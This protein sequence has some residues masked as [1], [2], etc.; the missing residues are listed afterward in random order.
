MATHTPDSTEPTRLETGTEA[1]ERRIFEAH[2]GGKLTVEPT[3]P[4]DNADDLAIV[5]TPG[6]A[7]VVE[8]I[9]EKPEKA[10][11]YTIKKNTVAV[12][13]DGSAILGL[14]D[15]GP[16]AAL[17]VMEGKAALFSRFADVDAFPICLDAHEVEDIVAHVKAIAPAFAGINLEDISAPR[18]FEIE[19]RLRAELDIP[20]FHDDQHGTAVCVLA[21]L[22]NALTIVEKP[23]EEVRIAMSGAGAAGT[24]ILRLLLA[25]G[26]RDVIVTNS[27]GIVRE[28]REAGDRLEWIARH[29][30]PRGVEG[31]L[32]EAVE[33]A[34]VFIG[35]SVPNIL[36]E[37]MLR[38]M[39][40]RA[41]V[42]AL[43]NPVPEV[44]PEIAWKYA[45]VV[46]TG[47]SDFANQINNVLAF[48]GVFRGLIDAH[49]CEVTDEALLAAAQAIASV[50]SEDE[51]SA[52][53]I[54]PSVFDERVTP[55]VARA[56]AR[57]GEP[58]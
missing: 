35:V 56:V 22:T 40:E 38:S 50:V 9:A 52:R 33:G 7:R 6:V 13:T 20:V 30:N 23:I 55:A 26:A 3:A 54:V 49:A 11:E 21:A 1:V 31:G 16:L 15:R 19:D 46:A 53:H 42:F 17:P 34:D 28:G 43:S 29:T 57:T 39:N 48:P 44:D 51:L 36:D 24:A 32:R 2:E 25:A 10:R 5:Y 41:I 18:C 14:G 37:S 45:T 27:K 8:E 12:V 58:R 4:I 47:R